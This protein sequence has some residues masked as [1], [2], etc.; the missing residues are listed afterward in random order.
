MHGFSRGCANSYA[1]V[2]LDRS[3]GSSFFKLIMSNSGGVMLDYPP[4]QD[5]VRGRFGASPFQ[6]LRWAMHGGMGYEN[7]EREG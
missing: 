5:M 1:L 6:G 7:P 2:A 3:S 4:D